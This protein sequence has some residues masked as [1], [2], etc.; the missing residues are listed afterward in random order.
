MML[1]MGYLGFFAFFI[2]RHEG[3][4]ENFDG[5]LGTHV[6][7]PYKALMRIIRRAV[8][9]DRFIKHVDEPMF[10][11]DN[12]HVVTHWYA[13]C[14]TLT[15]V[16]ARE[17]IGTRNA[18]KAFY[19]EKRPVLADLLIDNEPDKVISKYYQ[20]GFRSNP[21]VNQTYDAGGFYPNLGASGKWLTFS[22]LPLKDIQGR[23]IGVLEVV[24]DF[25][26][27]T[28]ETD[29][30]DIMK[31]IAQAEWDTLLFFYGVILCVGGLSQFGYLAA[32]SQFMYHDLGAT[33]ANALVGILSA[34]VDNIPV[35]FAVLTM[36]PEMSKGQWLLVT[37]T[38]G[39]GGSL[40]S[41]GSAAGVALMGSARGVY[42]FGAHL[43][44]T[45]AIFLGYV[46]SIICHL[47]IHAG[48]M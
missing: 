12:D 6:D 28:A 44:W 4:S 48:M 35:M 29:S 41:I 10:A 11:I 34:I 33:M 23:Q 26:V 17:M 31:R 14:E 5:I 25:A 32:I 37:L 24:Q 19:P 9:I 27:E 36:S 7:L 1:G 13:A 47:L 2:K 30:F 38:A 40:L 39:V 16:P 15:G 22:A 46:A 3:R 20:N 21:H 18:W 42:T 43:K 45:P 8:N